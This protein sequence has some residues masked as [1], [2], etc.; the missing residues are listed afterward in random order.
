VYAIL[1]SYEIEAFKPQVEGM[2]NARAKFIIV[3]KGE[4]Y[5]RPE[6]TW[7]CTLPDFLNEH[8]PNLK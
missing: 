6:E 3:Y 5:P 7:V 1:R 4:S 2:D 8:L